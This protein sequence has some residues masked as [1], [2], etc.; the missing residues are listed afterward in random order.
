MNNTICN[1]HNL[2]KPHGKEQNKS[3][4]DFEYLGRLN[5]LF[6]FALLQYPDKK[7]KKQTHEN[8]NQ[9]FTFRRH[10]NI[11]LPMFY[12]CSDSYPI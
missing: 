2:S 5:F 8:Y 10:R 3:K 11:D 6:N 4:K 9:N 1:Q 12:E 7:Y